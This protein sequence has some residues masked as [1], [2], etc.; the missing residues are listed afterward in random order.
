[1]SAALEV[2]DGGVTAFGLLEPQPATAKATM[3]L[4]ITA[5]LV[6][7]A[8]PPVAALLGSGRG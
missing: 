4:M 6:C 8:F 5:G 7:T 1:L 2:D 3:A